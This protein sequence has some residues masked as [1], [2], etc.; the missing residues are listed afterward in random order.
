MSNQKFISACVVYWESPG[1]IY[2]IPSDM[3]GAFVNMM[4][5]I[6]NYNT[7]DDIDHPGHLYK[8]LGTFDAIFWRYELDKTTPQLYIIN[9]E[10]NDR[11]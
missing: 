2:I 11:D 8:L 7:E 4:E 1:H 5:K 10:R 9:P 3:K 6:R